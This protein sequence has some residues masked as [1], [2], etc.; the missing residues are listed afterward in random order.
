MIDW[1]T[2]TAVLR[3][4]L[5]IIVIVVGGVGGY[6]GLRFATRRALEDAMDRAAADNRDLEGRLSARHGRLEERVMALE[7]ATD[8]LAAQLKELP[9]RREWHE[10][11]TQIAEV[12]GEL[13]ATATA[14]EGLRGLIARLEQP[15]AQFL[16]APPP[17][18]PR[19]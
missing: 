11:S 17:D 18:R 2:M 1:P 12:R 14:I 6:M 5:T 16:A 15:L 19:R 10:V 9:S 13:K 7:R 4:W 8:R 3:D